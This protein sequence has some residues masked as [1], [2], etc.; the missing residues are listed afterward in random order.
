MLSLCAQ[1]TVGGVRGTTGLSA[2]SAVDKEPAHEHDSA[3]GRQLREVVL[4]APVTARRPSRVQGI[5]VQVPA[6]KL[7]QH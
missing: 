3:T 2:R 1:W 4:S 7:C 6:A 5:L